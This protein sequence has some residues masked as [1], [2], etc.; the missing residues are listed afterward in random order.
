MDLITTSEIQK[1]GVKIL[2]ICVTPP[3]T[4]FLSHATQLSLILMYEIR[5]LYKHYIQLH[6]NKVWE[7]EWPTTFDFYIPNIVLKNVF[8]IQIIKNNT[9]KVDRDDIVDQTIHWIDNGYYPIFFPDETLLPGTLLYGRREPFHHLAFYYGY[10]KN[11]KIFKLLSFTDKRTYKNIDISFNDFI[12]SIYYD[13]SL[14]ND[15]FKKSIYL[16]VEL[17]KI[18]RDF[19]K[20]NYY[21]DTEVIKSVYVELNDYLNNTKSNFD[22]RIILPTQITWGIDIVYHNLMSMYRNE[23][24]QRFGLHGVVGFYQHKIVM[25]ERLKFLV[26]NGLLS[27]NTMYRFRY[28]CI[29]AELIKNLYIKYQLTKNRSILATLQSMMQ[30]IKY[31]ECH[32]LTDVLCQL[33]NN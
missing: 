20:N 23:Y 27:Q 30:D 8:D 12:T 22:E 1:N 11:S 21:T 26:K 7:T 14:K 32:I 33:Q 19:I 31:D 16:N 15:N 10:D 17:W 3:V 13:R 24:S 5:Y 4:M 18:Q 2:P 9:I 6:W 25:Q 28:L 29:K